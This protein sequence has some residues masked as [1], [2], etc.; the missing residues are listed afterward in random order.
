MSN[1]PT[2]IFSG[3]K[4][5]LEGV[6]WL[7]QHPRYLFV[8][9]VPA[10]L[11]LLSLIFILGLFFGNFFAIMD[12]IMFAR[13][14]MWLLVPLYWVLYALL[15]VVLFLLSFVPPL[16]VSSVLSS[17]FYEIVSCAVERE[18]LG[19]VVE[20]S[21]RQALMMIIEETKKVGFIL[22]ITLL[23]MLIPGLN[24][25]ALF[26]PAFLLGWDFCDYPLARRGWSFK[27]RLRF[28]FKNFWRVTGLGLWLIVPA[29]QFILAPLAVAGGTLLTISALD[30]A[31]DSDNKLNSE[32]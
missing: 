14:D 27:R 20:I 9:L 8:L 32:G 3:I 2:A 15:A 23:A 18:R 28:T 17:P 21:W 1:S 30:D 31:G 29:L 5:Y 6:R 22:A 12:G 25:L 11:G 19:K 4:I 13:P 16:L 10:L 26:I 24:V 7:R